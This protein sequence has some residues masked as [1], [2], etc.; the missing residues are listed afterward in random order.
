MKKTVKNV[1]PFGLICASLLFFFNPNVQLVDILPDLFG[2]ILL[3]AG[4]YY[5]ADLNESIGEARARFIKM[6]PVGI[7]KLIVFLMVF[8]GLVSPQEQSTF[9]LVAVLSFGV[10]ELLILVPATR[11]LFAGLMQLAT[12][13]GSEAIFA[14]KPKKIPE[15][16][17]K[18]FKKPSQ[19][20]AFEKKVARIRYRNSRLRCA[21]EKLQT[22][23]LLFLFLKPLVALLP[24]FSALSGTEYNDGLVNYYGF[25]T[26][27][28]GF[29]FIVLLPFA[30]VW[31]CKTWKFL[32]KL[33]RDT[34]FGEA[35]LAQ[36]RSE[37]LP[38]TDLF[39]QRA[40]KSALSLIALGMLFS[41]DFY[42]EYYNI[43][44][45]V[46]CA[47]FVIIGVCLLRKYIN[48]YKPVLFIA[49]GYGLVTLAANALTVW[50][51]TQYYFNA[52]YKNASAEL[53]FYGEGIATVLENLLFL[54]MLWKLMKLME[55]MIVRYSGFS[56]TSDRAPGASERI[57]RVHLNLKKTL[58]Q[59]FGFG[60]LMAVTGVLYE[61]LKPTVPYIWM[62]D[63]AVAIVY[64]YLFYRSTWEIREQVEYK[65]LLS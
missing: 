51:N 3:V 26:L 47:V 34:A 7:A 62:V 44:P 30:I 23:T 24:E 17:A 46:L 16:P 43:I 18:G 57:S 6:I 21:L 64:I 42:I 53:V 39:A 41:L 40:I 13:F 31:L 27:F 59:F 32:G 49:A 15:E 19:K 5:L 22:L 60:A 4:L 28:R 29:G 25:I 20:R 54:W 45:D 58:Y 55:Q 10:I 36:Y 52:I 65:Y 50:F 37:V 8:G 14:T 61:F 33:R 9:V 2:Y 56:V 1:F 35:C 38:K 12:K 11:A 63:F 48:G